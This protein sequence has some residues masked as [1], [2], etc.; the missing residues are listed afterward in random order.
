MENTN[1]YKSMKIN[2]Y[3][4]NDGNISGNESGNIK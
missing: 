4:N 2:Y 3:G 1:I